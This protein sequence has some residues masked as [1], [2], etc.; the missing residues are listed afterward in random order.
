MRRL[1]NT[2]YTKALAARGLAMEQDL[3]A[4]AMNLIVISVS[5]NEYVLFVG[6]H[7]LS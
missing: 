3:M 6:I 2:E 7:C 5:L 4:G 1:G